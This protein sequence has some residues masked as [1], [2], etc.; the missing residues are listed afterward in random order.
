VPVIPALGIF[1]APNSDPLPWDKY[2]DKRAFWTTS[3]VP[4]GGHVVIERVECD[5]K[6][7]ARILVN[8][9][10]HQLTNCPS[11]MKNTGLCELSDFERIIKSS[12]EKSFCEV[13]APE[14]TECI[15]EISFF[16]S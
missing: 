7:Y 2:D 3:I 9:K 16:E 12:W 15:A 10:T 4:M 5:D 1:P 8:G 6:T 11:P 13:C 14:Q